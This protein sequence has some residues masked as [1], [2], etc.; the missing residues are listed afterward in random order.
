METATS[1]GHWLKQRRKA[2]DLTQAELAARVG[3]A[4]MT[5][6]KIEA[7]ER[8]PSKELAG[9]L[10]RVLRVPPA[11]HATFVRIARGELAAEQLS[12]LVDQP[13]APAART[14][15]A[16]RPT[17]PRP[18]TPLIGRERELAQ[19][20]ALV[21]RDDVG[22]VTLTG[23]GGTG[24]TRLAIAVA[25]RLEAA[26][27]DGVQFVALGPLT[28][29]GLVPST[30]ATAL[31]VRL[32]GGGAPDEHLL[33]YLGPKHVLLVLDNF[34]HLLP[35]SAWVAE[36]LQRC[37]VLTVLLTSRA[38]LHLSAEHAFPVPPL[39]LPEVV[40]RGGRLQAP[41]LDQVCQSDAVRLF[42][43]RTQAIRPDFVL[44]DTTAPAV[45]AI[46]RQL[47]G[48]PLALEL[49]A[50]RC[51]VLSVSA[52]SERLAHRL[53]LLTHAARDQPSRHQ[54]LRRTIAWSYDLLSA[55][56]QRMFRWLAVF[57]GG[58]T[59][60]AVEVLWADEAQPAQ[61][62]DLVQALT[63]KSLVR[64][65]EREGGELRFDMLETLRAF[66]L[67]QLV[68]GGEYAV[69]CARHAQLYVALAE[70][71]APTLEGGPQQTLGFQRLT[72]ERHNL[73]AV[74]HWAS[75][76][77]Q[78]ELGLRLATALQ[79]YW[80]ING[81]V[82]E[83]RRWLDA[84]LLASA[85]PDT[86]GHAST[87]RIIRA[88]ALVAAG[89][90]AGHQ[91]DEAAAAIHYRHALALYTEP[92][93]TAQRAYTL[94]QLASL[95]NVH[96][97]AERQALLEDG[98]RLY[99]GLSDMR[100]VG[101]VLLAMSDLALERDD[102]EWA[103]A[104]RDEAVT[105]ARAT[106]DRWQ[107]ALALQ[108]VADL[109]VDQ[110]EYARA[111]AVYSEGIALC[112]AIGEHE[113]QAWMLTGLAYCVRQQGDLARASALYRE[114]L[115]L[116]EALGHRQGIADMLQYQGWVA[117]AAGDDAATGLF[118]RALVRCREVGS[119]G[120]TAQCLAGLAAVAA[121]QQQPLR[122]AR[123]FAAA[124]VY[125]APRGEQPGMYD[126]AYHQ[127]FQTAQAQLTQAA[128]DG[129]WA[130]G[131]QMA[132][133]QACAYALGEPQREG[134][135]RPVRPTSRPPAETANPAGLTAREVEVLRVVAEGGTDQEV[136]AR[137]GL[138]PRTVTTY[139]TRIYA[140]L[141]VRTRTAAVRVAREQHLI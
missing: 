3:C 105:I 141:D 92:G 61:I 24:K 94:V 10:A 30:V 36:L 120:E 90:L 57:R 15:P 84:Q 71:I 132:V 75:T 38:V 43:T 112:R 77:D 12:D 65:M 74:L 20:C 35:A 108:T 113:D 101:W 8:R 66:A 137:L 2:L 118:Q 63:E 100:N 97:G 140:K 106:G 53:D 126:P 68:L 5:I 27:P 1:F 45:A 103:R 133:E 123:L 44:D 69:A 62:L 125:L 96:A 98:L 129:A 79:R 111:A 55:D 52:L 86:H 64:R 73:E 18:P 81:L 72:S 124:D 51:N 58:W 122:A 7:E 91:G 109:L 28:D 25:A 139:L 22:L 17:L 128:W 114:A 88:P 60:E 83:G 85:A 134:A 110:R 23:P 130:E 136:A 19:L 59:L 117:L 11:D 54:S 80:I 29:P 37:P 93:D 4:M 14:S 116:F 135:V 121:R 87:G 39:T 102:V 32:N 107:L 127:W 48:L 119:R 6:Q 89:D 67:E 47:D 33:A 21:L 99:R 70:G 26:F 138:R 13:P 76:G 104:L 31:G 56:E 16:R 41:P 131:E 34:E 9:H 42:E 50:A 46:C 40:E 95:A 78:A 49:A 82:G 115:A